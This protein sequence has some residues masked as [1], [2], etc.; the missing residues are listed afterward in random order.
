LA[1]LVEEAACEASD[2][3]SVVVNQVI[4]AETAVRFDEPIAIG[5]F[6]LNEIARESIPWE[7]AF[8][9][10]Q[11]H[12]QYRRRGGARERTLPDF[13]IGAH[14]RVMGY[15]LLTRDPRRYRGYFPDVE[16]IAPDTHP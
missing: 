15:L 6:P 14:A 1:G 7:A 12:L 13:L 3:G 4:F 11:A 2:A 16:L 5:I 9:A 10:G 8:Q